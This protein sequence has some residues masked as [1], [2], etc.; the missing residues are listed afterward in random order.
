MSEPETPKERQS[1]N[2]ETIKLILQ[3]IKKINEKLTELQ[4]RIDHVESELW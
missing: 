2:Y 4:N 1:E 3:D